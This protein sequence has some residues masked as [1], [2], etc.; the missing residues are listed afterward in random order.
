M[1]RTVMAAAWMTLA[2]APAG[3][4]EAAA[5]PPLQYRNCAQ[6][7][8]I[9][10]PPQRILAL[11]QHAADLVLALGGHDRLIGVA[12]LDDDAEAQASGQYQ[13]I[14]V[15]ARHYPSMEAVLAYGSDF[16]VGGFATAFLPGRGPATRDALT[17]EGIGSYLVED[18]C[19]LPRPAGDAF[20]T[21]LHDLRTLGRLLGADARGTAL[22]DALQA[23]VAAARARPLPRPLSVLV[24]DSDLRTP[25]VEGARGFTTAM[26]SLA[27]ARNVFDDVDL[28]M[29][30]V[31]W[32]EVV[33]RSP[34]IILLVDATW[35]TAA[36][37]R[38]FLQQDPILS[39]LPAVRAGRFIDMRFTHGV[40]GVKSGEALERL[41]RELHALAATLPAPAAR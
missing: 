36:D 35:S 12:W 5:S 23:Q 11:N 41:T 38:A 18:A 3:A 6:D 24:F 1:I 33:A 13:G 8:Q 7:W 30:T 40:P 19:G 15:L 16:L 28:G 32:E 14:P 22:A 34:D 21:V 4:A 26:L 27:G 9:A 20:D 10:A 39:T 37:K 31:S 25:Y 17:A 29:A 2:A